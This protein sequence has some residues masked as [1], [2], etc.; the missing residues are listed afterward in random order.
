MNANNKGL[1][2]LSMTGT[3]TELSAIDELVLSESSR[4]MFR[5]GRETLQERSICVL[6]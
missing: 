5:Q 6:Y 2:P 4:Q 1:N 3:Q